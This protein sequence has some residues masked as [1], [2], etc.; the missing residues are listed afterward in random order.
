MSS[1]VRR[2][3]FMLSAIPWIAALYGTL[4]MHRLDANLGHSICGPWGC[5][6]TTEALIGYHTFW[7]VLMLPIAIAARAFLPNT[8]V[9]RVGL[10]LLTTGLLIIVGYVGWDASRFV[11]QA[12][13]AA[14]LGQRCF[15]TLVTSVDM[16]MMQLALLGLIV[17]AR[18]KRTPA[19]A[20][21]SDQPNNVQSESSEP[22]APM[23]TTG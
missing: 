8:A 10:A 9:R 22:V 6:P 7:L 18:R 3:L 15:F 17:T 20:N 5:G 11:A 1:P 4:Q 21:S 14:Y 16:P 2:L 12:N 23:H 13:S 19:P